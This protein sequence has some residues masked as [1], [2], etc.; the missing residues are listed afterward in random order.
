MKSLFSFHETL[1]VVEN[2]ILELAQDAANVQTDAHKKVKS[3]Y[4]I[5]SAEDSEKEAWYILVKYYEGEEV[6]IVKL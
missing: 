2:D 3:A 5:Q 1:E 6:K 4:Y